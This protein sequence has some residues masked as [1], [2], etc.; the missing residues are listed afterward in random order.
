MG[1]DIEYFLIKDGLGF[2]V[3][4][5]HRHFFFNRAWYYTNHSTALCL[6]EPK[7]QPGGLQ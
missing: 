4:L 5:L 6:K 3:S 1:Q 2:G 7:E